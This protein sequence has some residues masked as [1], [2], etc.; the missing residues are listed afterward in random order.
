MRILQIN[1]LISHGSTGVIA[2]DIGRLLEKNGHEVFFASPEP[3]DSV[4]TYQIGNKLD[5]KIHASLCRILGLQ[6]YFSIFATL[7]L[8]NWING[9]KPDIIQIHNLHSNYINYEILFSYIRM[10]RIRT[11]ITL[12]DCWFFTGKCFHYLYNGCK[13]WMD[14]CGNCP[15]L[16]DEQSSLFFDRTRKVLLDKKRY[17]GQNESVE[18][19][20]VSKWIASQASK[21]VIK[22][23]K[24]TV[25]HN[26]IDL[27]V[28]YPR[29]IFNE[30]FKGFK[31]KFVIMG[32]ANKWLYEENIETFHYIVENLSD[33]E[34][35]LLVGCPEKQ[36]KGLPNKVV[37]V[38]FSDSDFLAQLYSRAD[39]F[40]NLT[41]VDTYP[42]VNM[43]ALACGTPVVTFDSGGSKECIIP[44]ETGYVAK[45]GDK[46]AILHSIHH[47]RENGKSRYACLCREYAIANCD[48]N[49]CYYEYL[50]LYET[51]EVR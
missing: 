27:E 10:K 33:D 22:E 23:R 1:A 8:I 7:K 25:I 16:H 39:V 38:P 20:A 41:K 28:F 37:G 50:K 9:I 35:I 6:G 30:Y 44:G 21:S 45:F 13:K 43:E 46:E 11:V 36:R 47:V 48:K 42:T 14:C 51:G 2:K 32:M 29:Q 31:D 18:L 12:H 15:R 40:V 49:R 19:V 3:F 24:I 5:H 4:N 34:L 26:G 17:I